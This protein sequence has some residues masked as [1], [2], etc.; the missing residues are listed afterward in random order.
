M[1]KP[2]ISVLSLLTGSAIGAGVVKKTLLKNKQQVQSLADKHLALFLMM[3]QW[4]KVKQ[5][6]KNL[7]SYFEEHGYKK[8]A[9]YGMSYAGETF[10]DELRDT[11]VEIVYGIDK[12]TSALNV[13]LE[14]VSVDSELEE[15]DAV[16]VT[17]ITYFDDIEKALSAKL[18][19]PILSLEDILYEV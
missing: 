1:N 19:C 14:V 18:N 17:A 7:T 9:I 10:F 8:I 12:K 16:V 6:G 5:E 2:V 15:V 3:N 11:S 4:V 13:E